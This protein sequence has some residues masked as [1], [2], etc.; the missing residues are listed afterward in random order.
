MRCVSSGDTCL[1]ERIPQGLRRE[2]AI[3][4]IR[5]DLSQ[6]SVTLDLNEMRD[7]A[8]QR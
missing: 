7:R 4:V 1:R 6:E 2:G 5:E 8:T 3:T